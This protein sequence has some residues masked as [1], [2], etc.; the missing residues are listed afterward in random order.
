MKGL[1]RVPRRRLLTLAM[2]A[3]GLAVGACAPVDLLN[4]WVPPDS[5]RRTRNI[6]YGSHPRQRLDIHAPHG[7]TRPAQ[8]VVFFY[9]GAWESGAR[10]DYLFAAEG[11][12][13]AGFIVVVPDYR[14]Y[15]EVRFPS[16]LEDCAGALAWVCAHIADHGGDPAQIFLMG[17]SAGAYNAAMLALDD[18]YLAKESLDPSVIR[19]MVGLAGPY[20][21]LPIT[22]TTLKQVFA[23]PDMA[24]TQPITFAHGKAPPMLL[25]TGDEDETVEP[26]NS[27]SLASRLRS[28]GASATMRVYAGLGHIGIV[29]ALGRAFRDK[30]PVLADAADFMR[31]HRKG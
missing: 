17:H 9:G 1:A 19:G 20:D 7:P 24:A 4:A 10:G 28:A 13:S 14:L 8:T 3:A 21:F 29:T 23:S 2:G 5:H 30:A 26:R 25:L 18:R 6:A 27:Q 16:F 31:E 15:P 11:L 12:V 22:G